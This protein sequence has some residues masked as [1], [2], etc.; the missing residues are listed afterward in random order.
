MRCDVAHRSGCPE[1][2]RKRHINF[3]LCKKRPA[4]RLVFCSKD[5]LPCV[6]EKGGCDAKNGEAETG[7]GHDEVDGAGGHDICGLRVAVG[8][9]VF[10]PLGL[11]GDVGDDVEEVANGRETDTKAQTAPP[12]KGGDAE[13]DGGQLEQSDDGRG[14]RRPCAHQRVGKEFFRRFAG[15]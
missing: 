7:Q 1:G 15:G 14:C 12:E 3:L 5:V 8:R 11:L 10:E 4:Q 9:D 6:P 13:A 2:A